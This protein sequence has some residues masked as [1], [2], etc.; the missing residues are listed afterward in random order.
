MAILLER[1]ASPIASRTRVIVS[2]ASAQKSIT[3]SARP[4]QGTGAVWP[5]GATL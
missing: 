5:R 3:K 4:P 1:K 2:S